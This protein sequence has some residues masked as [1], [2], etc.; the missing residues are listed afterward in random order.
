MSLLERVQR[1]VAPD[2]EV[3]RE[4]GG[5]GMGLV[6]LGHEPTLDRPVAVKVLRP[7]I[8][9]AAAADRFL[10]EARLLASVVHPNVVAIH[11]VAEADGYF[12]FVMELLGGSL[13]GRL[14]QGRLEPDEVVRIGVGLLRGLAKVHE[15]GI[16]H[17][18][19]KPSNIFLRD[20]VPVL[21]DFGIA[22]L[23]AS[24]DADLTQP[25]SVVGTPAYSAPEQLAGGEVTPLADLYAAGMVLYEAAT[26][27]RW[28]G[29][30]DPEAADWHDVPGWLTS[31]LQ[32]ALA[33]E[34]AARWPTAEA[35]AEAL[36]RGAA[37]AREP[38]GAAAASRRRSLLSGAIGIA[39]V[40][41][42]IVIV[43]TIFAPP[44]PPSAEAEIAMVPPMAG[45]TTE[46]STIAVA[47]ANATFL[48]L[49]Q[50]FREDTL[51]VTPMSLVDQ[52]WGRLPTHDSLPASA[53]KDLK[54][55][56]IAW[57]RL[58]RI[59]D[60]LRVRVEVREPDG[61]VRP[62]AQ[63]T[64]RVDDASD[65]GF[66]IAQAIVRVILPEKAPRFVG[67]PLRGRSSAALDTLMA[68]DRA[69]WSDNWVAAERFYQRAIVL[70]SAL[71]QAWWGLY[72]VR[73]WRR[74]PF[75]MDLARVYERHAQD[76]PDLDAL[77]IQ[78]DLAAGEERLAGY[79]AAIKAFPYNAYPWLLLGNELFH[80]G[81]L[82]GIGL[83]SAVTV[84]RGSADRNPYMAPTYSMLAWAL[85]RQGEA[86]AAREAVE[87]YAQVASPVAEQEFCVR[88]VLELV[89]AERFAPEQAAAGRAELLSSRAGPSSLG[90]SLRLGLSFE[91]PVAQ[92][93]LG[94]LLAASAPDRGGRADALTAQAVAA[95]ALGEVAT[96]LA[97]LDS[98]ATVGK[99]PETAFQA[100]EWRVVLPALGVPGVAAAERDAGRGEV[101][102]LVQDGRVGT[103]ARWTLA[104][105]ALAAG[106]TAT[107]G[108]WIARLKG[109]SGAARLAR[110]AMAIAAGAA[111]RTREALELSN[112]LVPL[113]LR[114]R[115]G[116]PFARAA[117]Y[118]ERGHWLEKRDKRAADRAW[119]WYENAD[120][121]GWPSGP[122]QAAEID[123]ALE[124]YGRYLRGMLA[125]NARDHARVCA[126][127]PDV[128][129][130][131]RQADSAYA[132]LLRRARDATAGCAH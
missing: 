71:A 88:C 19:V 29:I 18:D 55:R 51:R 129:A 26:G 112:E 9:T 35:F 43:R 120:F 118:L 110:L 81:A 20:D 39:F 1:A 33:L 30:G 111:G 65:L 77:L 12:Y 87:R 15:R 125:Q 80:R 70:D 106:D 114:E 104:L 91:V 36:E 37:S 123:W 8:A 13:D 61:T 115:L 32:R 98:A 31:V 131:W 59:G 69:F 109:D 10:R 23:S 14:K 99:D 116:D 57:G 44:S 22:K 96:A 78:A 121:S 6:F 34:P 89:L 53:W 82:L 76:F 63:V 24:A 38:Q 47:V 90:R 74:V 72:N 86:A 42:V 4:L 102:R 100:V 92:F 49:D 95:L 97:H 85:I 75:D 16:V 119:L 48:H 5:G 107:A 3:E 62:G 21:G 73:R 126:L 17:R 7:E 52:W 94:H 127:L 113:A 84:L 50:A 45:P 67:S 93:A 128:V 40:A 28:A 60:T 56:R 41:V 122:P 83:D 68:G 117:L 27:R 54:T 103:R 108:T 58:E 66:A 101:T 124:A 130:R 11:R 132:P 64:G 2:Y 46:D 79:R 25:G 105:D